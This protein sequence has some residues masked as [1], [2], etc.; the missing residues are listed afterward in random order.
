MPVIEERSVK[1]L[2]FLW[3]ELTRKCNLSCTHCYA[4]SGP[5]LPLKGRLT[6]GDWM[7]VISEARELGCS[8]VQ[9]I[10]GEPLLHTGLEDL[11][12]HSRKIGI[13]TIEIFTNSTALTKPKAQLFARYGVRF[14]TSF[15]SYEAKIHDNVTGK[16]GSFEKT[17]SGIENIIREE[18]PL[19]VEVID[20]SGS[21]DN[22]DATRK[23]LQNLGV[24]GISRN[25]QQ[26]VGRGVSDKPHRYSIGDLCGNCGKSRGCITADGTVFPCI[27]ARSQA[28]GNVLDSP[29]QEIFGCSALLEFR[30]TIDSE[31]RIR[32]AKKKQFALTEFCG[33][34]NCSPDHAC[35]PDNGC[36]P[37]TCGPDHAC[38][39]DHN[40]GPGNN[41]CGPDNCGPDN[42]NCPPG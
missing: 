19:R 11:V 35:S 24:K 10:G 14:A 40:C 20:L 28:L 17:V 25:R 39:P 16:I 36:G 21:D 23:Y 33:P 3:L 12:A 31:D 8:A 22:F 41:N 13:E 30:S 9:F 29:L 42:H 32:A 6:D 7:R 27:M 2:N 37:D 38:G 15:Y 1:L 26:A 34:D 18:L 5:H 4:E